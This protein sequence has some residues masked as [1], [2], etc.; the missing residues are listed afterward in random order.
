M[1]QFLQVFTILFIFLS[2]S[3][4]EHKDS[5]FNVPEMF[6]TNFKS[7]KFLKSN[8]K[9]GDILDFTMNNKKI[10]GI[11]IDIQPEQNENL[12][13]ICFISNGKLFG[14]KI[15]DGITENC[16]ELLDI[17]F[18]N[19]KSLNNFEIKSNEK[20]NFSKI[21]IGSRSPANDLRDIFRDFE[22]GIQDRKK[23]ETSCSEKFKTLNPINE[24]Y[25]ALQQIK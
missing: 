11:I 25:F 15:P 10:S 7:A 12:I 14:R 5:N 23:K 24:C 17:T 18:I 13:G 9:Y 1:K 3:S 2:C 21:G 8:F 22:T 6:Q 4:K 16:I 19:E 20:L